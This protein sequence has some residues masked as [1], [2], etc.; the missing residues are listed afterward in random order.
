MLTDK[1]INFSNKSKS[2]HLNTFV[3]LEFQYFIHQNI[4]DNFLLLMDEHFHKDV[5]E[6][7][8]TIRNNVY[9]YF[10]CLR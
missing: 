10:L 8:L 4:V 7:I 6:L 3:N 1:L 5:N 9:L 2:L